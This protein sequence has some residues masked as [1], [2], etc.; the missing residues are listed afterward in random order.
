MI[1]QVVFLTLNEP[2]NKTINALLLEFYRKKWHK[3][4][5]LKINKIIELQ[6]RLTG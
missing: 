1:W 3:V 4:A 2:N 5:M 6:K